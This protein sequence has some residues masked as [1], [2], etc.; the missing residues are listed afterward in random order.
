MSFWKYVIPPGWVF[1]VLA[2]SFPAPVKAAD[3]I[4]V[5]GPWKRAHAT[6]YDGGPSTYGGACDF[7]DVV[8]E[9]YGMNTAALS[10][11]L[12]K[13]GEAC[14][15][16][17]ELRCVDDPQWCKLGKPSLIITATDHC[18]PNPSQPSDNG[19]WCNPP[20][21]HFDIARPAFKT[22]AEEKGGIIPVEYRRVPCKKQGGIRFTILGNPY[23]IEVVIT[24]VAG[25]GDVT[26]ATDHCPPNPS[27]PNDN[28]GWC[29][30]PLEH[31][32]IAHPAFGQL[33]EEKSGIIPVEYRRVP[34]QKRGGIRFT[35]LG[36]PW[37]I[38]VIVT[39]VAGAGDVKSVMVKGDK[40]PWTR[41]ER[42]WGETWKTG[43]HELVGESLTFRVKTTDGRS[44]TA[45][46]VAPKDW[47][48]GQTY[49]G[50]K[51]FRM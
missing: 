1:L 16:C 22:L 6:F 47:Q 4:K 48:F 45:W 13:E 44:C 24:N 12:F 50:K 15:A 42:D 32:D 3:T 19:G 25:A 30:P 29:N 14:G 10:G 39:N 21:E 23:F 34:C 7:K 46:H 36:N 33:A 28:G 27:L 17:F 26:T 38:Q 5:P 9:G 31:F 2:L 40:V 37:F 8:Q 11:A 18:P 20:R 41:M 43:V 35:I 51:N 49:E